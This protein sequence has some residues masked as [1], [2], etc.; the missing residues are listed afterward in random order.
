MAININFNKLKIG[1]TYSRNFLTEYWGY[2]GRQ[3]ISRGVVTPANS[4]DII[5]F[6]TKDKQRTSTQYDDYISDNFLYWEGE[7]EGGSN[8]RI[9][10]ASENADPIH[11]FYRYIH[12]SDFEYMGT[13]QLVSFLEMKDA[14][15]KFIFKISN[16]AD[17][18]QNQFNEPLFSYGS[19]DTTKQ[20]LA[21]SRIGQGKF[22]IDLLNMWDAC[23]LTNVKVPE[24]LRASHI[25]PWRDSNDFERLDP[26]NGL[27]LTPTL[28]SLFDRGF[29]TFE[30]SGQ[31]MISKE[32]ADYSKILNISSDMKLLKHFEKND[33][34][35][36]YHRDE[37]YLNRFKF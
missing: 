9:I 14:P 15:F 33:H 10:S 20:T 18:R 3:A 1:E 34:Y 7:K 31:I 25:K 8:N 17:Q 5:F 19:K 27:V 36:E 11:L 4:N 6:V 13:I 29:I 28:D 21:L 12:R 16:E 26:N 32:I 22:R 24:I 35:L 37:I 23:S 2:Q 30:N